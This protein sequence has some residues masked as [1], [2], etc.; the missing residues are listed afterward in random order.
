MYIRQDMSTALDGI[1]PGL[2]T[3]GATNPIDV[4]TAWLVKAFAEFVLSEEGQDMLPDF[5]FVKMPTSLL[6]KAKTEL[7]SV[8]WPAAQGARGPWIF[9]GSKNKDLDGNTIVG[10]GDRVFSKKRKAFDDHE[11]GVIKSD[12]ALLQQQV[13]ALSAVQPDRWYEDPAKQI[14]PPPPSERSDSSSGSSRSSSAP[15]RSPAPT[16]SAPTAPLSRAACRS[17]RPLRAKL[18]TVQTHD[19]NGEK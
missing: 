10:A 5:G 2:N 9:E 3:D 18:R 8:V 13:E 12:I 14:G 17:E 15:S 16:L 7:A 1:N 6:T 4:D 11:R 19:S